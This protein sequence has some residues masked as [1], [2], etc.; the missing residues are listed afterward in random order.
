MDMKTAFAL[1][2]RDIL[3]KNMRSIEVREGLV[4]KCEKMLKETVTTLKVRNKE[5]RKF[6]TGRKMRQK[7]PLSPR[8]FTLLIAHLDEELEKEGGVMVREKDLFLAYA[9]DVALVTKDEGRM[10]GMI[11]VLQKYVERKG[12]EVN[13]RKI[14]IMR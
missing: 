8:L 3:L 4:V 10:K 6:W 5:G 13:M 7:C 14:K 1:V 11:R 2:N 12:L 9:D